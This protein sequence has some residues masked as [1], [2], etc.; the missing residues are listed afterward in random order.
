[1]TDY[2]SD[3]LRDYGIDVEYEYEFLAHQGVKGMKWGVRKDEKPQGYQGR[4][5]PGVVATRTMGTDFSIGDAMNVVDAKG[6]S[7]SDRK[8]AK[9]AKY[10]AKRTRENANKALASPALHKNINDVNEKY[11]GTKDSPKVPKGKLELGYYYRDYV[12]ALNNEFSKYSDMKNSMISMVEPIMDKNLDIIGFEYLY[13]DQAYVD[14]IVKHEVAPPKGA[15]QRID[16]VVNPR[17][18]MIEGLTLKGS[19]KH[20]GLSRYPKASGSSEVPENKL[21]HDSLAHHGVKGMKWGVRKD[22]KPQGYQGEKRRKVKVNKSFRKAEGNKSVSFRPTSKRS[23]A[24]IRADMSDADLQKAVNRLRLE[25]EYNKQV[26]E[27]A[28]ANRSRG[29]IAKDHVMEVIT[30]ASKQAA[31]NLISSKLTAVGRDALKLNENKDPDV[32]MGDKKKKKKSGDKKKVNEPSSPTLGKQKTQS[33]SK[34]VDI[35][36]YKPSPWE[37]SPK[38]TVV[39][40]TQ[41]GSMKVQDLPSITTKK[42]K[43]IT[44]R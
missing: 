8:A 18:G 2:A 28:K 39:D 19:I 3:I 38:V 31:A 11:F 40:R 26:S 1:M 21:Q 4:K 7:K 23:V 24:P 12:G 34:P 15:R 30:K 37:S 33:S 22:G 43:Q 10:L 32:D 5:M 13:G 44:N 20:S 9:E 17:T 41:K 16:A 35:P 42:R 29:A 6:G 14:K 25:N 36:K 27:L